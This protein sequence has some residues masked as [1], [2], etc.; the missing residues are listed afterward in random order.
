MLQS[1]GLFLYGEKFLSNRLKNKTITLIITGGIAAYKTLELVR[2]LR[3]AGASI[4]PV[5][6]K[7]GAQFVTP[8]SLSALSESPVYDDLWSLKDDAQMG[9]I[10]LARSCDL[11]I[12]APVTANTMAKMA[13]GMAN[14]LASCIILATNKPVL[15]APA[16]NPFMWDNAAT[17]DNVKILKKR[18]LHFT[19]PEAGK[20]ACGEEGHGRMSEPEIILKC[21]CN[22]LGKK[23]LNGYKAIVTS[24]PTYEPIDPVRFIGNRSSG[25]QGHA[26]AKALAE[27]GAETTLITGPVALSDPYGVQTI[28]VESAKDM[29]N[30][31]EKALP[32]DIVVCAAAV[33][34]WGPKEI[35]NHKIKKR[36]GKTP[37]A[38]SLSE[39]PDILR[40][41]SNKGKQRP[42]LVIGF[43]A[44]T[45]QVIDAATKK[46]KD[47]GCDWIL[48]NDVSP[49][50]NVFG[51][52]E[53]HVYLLTH[54]EKDNISFEEWEKA[55]KEDVALRLVKR[56]TKEIKKD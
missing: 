45:E 43:A 26:I 55:S 32:A 8:L 36:A 49:D 12:V 39:N 33:A 56:I 5:L 50:E 24:G 28:H 16:M 31:T 11:V 15:L 41:I 14:D 27:A 34:D 40:T 53:N 30:A 7:S 3:K 46:I 25:K 37:P 42:D 4:Q 21:A 51:G 19:G 2:L 35:H 10:S 13:H 20:A 18:G 1:A 23:P 52:D 44:E 6:T 54:S 22:L 47:K 38:L 17:Q 29:L 9:H 48:A